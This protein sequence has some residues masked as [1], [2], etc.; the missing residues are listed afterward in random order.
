MSA[1][2]TVREL[3]RLLEQFDD[4]LPV[5]CSTERAGP[6]WPSRVCGGGIVPMIAAPST[7]GGDISV[8]MPWEDRPSF[9]A[10]LL[11]EHPSDWKP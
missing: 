8:K 5:F 11:G 1:P 7:T 3:K 10:L 4:D 2:L 6:G 9:D